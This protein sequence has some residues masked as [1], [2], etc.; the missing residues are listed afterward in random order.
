MATKRR[1]PTKASKIPRAP[2]VRQRTMLSM[3]AA[4]NR[5]A[6]LKLRVRPELRLSRSRTMARANCRL[7]RFTQAIS[8]EAE[9]CREK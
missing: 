1:I 8:K 3:N 9:N 5:R 2:P 6:G 7:A 4:W